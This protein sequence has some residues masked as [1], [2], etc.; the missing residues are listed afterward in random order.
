MQMYHHNIFFSTI[1]KTLVKVFVEK[2]FLV[3][4]CCE[5][6]ALSSLTKAINQAA[7]KSTES[8]YWL[9]LDKGLEH[10]WGSFRDL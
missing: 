4:C 7:L 6:Q 8:L 9:N 10:P 2:K 5:P 1:Y 3:G